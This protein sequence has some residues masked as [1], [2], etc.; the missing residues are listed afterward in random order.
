[1]LLYD[2]LNVFKVNSEDTS[3][4]SID[5]VMLPLLL[6]LGIFT[7]KSKKKYQFHWQLSGVNMFKVFV[8]GTWQNG[9]ILQCFEW[10]HENEGYR[11]S[12]NFEQVFLNGSNFSVVNF[13]HVFVSGE[14]T[15]RLNVEH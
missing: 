14:L 2:Q 13:E 3:P 1:M 9:N 4:M 6:T 7:K 15:S 5:L 8:K 12:V 10:R 11:H